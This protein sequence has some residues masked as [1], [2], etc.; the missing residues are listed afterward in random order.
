VL[1]VNAPVAFAEEYL[2]AP[3][4]AYLEKYPQVRIDLSMS[5][6]VTDLVGEG[7]DVAIRITSTVRDGGLVARKFATDRTVLCASP[8][9]LNRRG[10]PLTAQDLVHHDC[11][12]YSLLKAAD[13]W[14][15]RDSSRRTP[16]SLPIEGRFCAS[17]GAVLRRAVLAGMGLAVLPTFM[18]AADLAAGRLRPVVES[19]TGAE[20]N[21]FA[22]Y[23]HAAQ[24][25]RPPAKVRA[26]VDVLVA[27]FRQPPWK[28]P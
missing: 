18:V 25:S 9:Y 2:A 17:S 6:T 20:L 10:T 7:I 12:I 24:S 16:V 28:A 14:R 23:P 27:A 19:F 11:L 8:A 15:F 21:L 22:V 26:F 1:R 5:D 13:E 3:M 4:A